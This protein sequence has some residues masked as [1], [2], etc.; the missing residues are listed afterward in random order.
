MNFTMRNA[1]T[2]LM[3]Y[4]RENNI[5]PDITQRMTYTKDEFKTFMFRLSDETSIEF[6]CL[7]SMGGYIFLHLTFVECDIC[8]G[9]YSQADVPFKEADFCTQK[10]IYDFVMSYYDC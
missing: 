10:E 9:T 2:N 7:A 6:N 5:K 8:L 3:S 1:M 4:I